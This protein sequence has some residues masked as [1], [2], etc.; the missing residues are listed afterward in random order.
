MVRSARRQHLL[1]CGWMLQVDLAAADYQLPR[2]QRMWTHLDRQSGGGQVKG[3]GEK[4]KEVDKRLLRCSSPSPS[5]MQ[6]AAVTVVPWSHDP[7]ARKA[8]GTRSVASP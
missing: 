5:L 4:Q 3:M 7:G 2:L 6:H 8:T 1:R